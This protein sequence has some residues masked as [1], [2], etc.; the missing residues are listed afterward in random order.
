MNKTQRHKQFLKLWIQYK[1][2]LQK[3]INTRLGTK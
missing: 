1:K 3:L 2:H